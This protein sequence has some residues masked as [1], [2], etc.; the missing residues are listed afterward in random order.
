MALLSLPKLVYNGAEEVIFSN[1][2][3]VAQSPQEVIRLES[4]IDE[5]EPGSL[6]QYVPNFLAEL[7]LRLLVCKH[8]TKANIE[9]FWSWWDY[10]KFGKEFIY[11]HDK[12]VSSFESVVLSPG[13]KQ[14]FPKV[15]NNHYFFNILMEVPI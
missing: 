10:V 12:D 13:Y 14:F 11:Y 6:V 3:F 15:K 5:V 4:N 2:P 1:A 7:S 9:D 8:I